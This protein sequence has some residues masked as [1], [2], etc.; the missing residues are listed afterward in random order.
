MAVDL[1][2]L[3]SDVQRARKAVYELASRGSF[4]SNSVF[5]KAGKEELVQLNIAKVKVEL[6]MQRLQQGK[7]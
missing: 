2:E 5:M 6:F 3:E 7:V 4:K 1:R